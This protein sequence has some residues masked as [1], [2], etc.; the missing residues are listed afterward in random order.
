MTC[1]FL[2]RA[3]FVAFHPQWYLFS[4]LLS[5]KLFFNLG[6]AVG[7][8]LLH[9]LRRY[10]TSGSRGTKDVRTHFDIKPLAIV[11]CSDKEGFT[12]IALSELY[13]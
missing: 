6:M 8:A 5:F 10:V 12:G 2:S 4:R 9:T 7:R 3:S 11:Q 13:F 1:S